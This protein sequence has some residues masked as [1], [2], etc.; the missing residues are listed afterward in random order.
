MRH[1]SI[2]PLACYAVIV[3]Y[4]CYAWF[5]IGHWPYYA[6]PDPKELPHRVLL[7]IASA[8]F[9]AGLLSVISIPAGYLLWRAVASWQ[10]R[11]VPPH[12]TPVVLYLTGVAV[13]VLDLIAEF[14]RV[15]WSSNI[16][17]LMD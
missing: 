13:W 10:K 12:R 1:F 7:D 5:Q 8:V 9:L 11:P 14:T 16:G 4:G 15:F 2:L 6:H 17:W 3:C